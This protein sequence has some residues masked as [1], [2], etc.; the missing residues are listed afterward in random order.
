MIVEVHPSPD[1]ALSDGYQSLD[2]DQ[3][4]EMMQQCNRIAQAVERQLGSLQP[5]TV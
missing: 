2:F 5:A 4:A 3:F 1:K